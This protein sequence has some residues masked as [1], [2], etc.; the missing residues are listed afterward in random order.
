MNSVDSGM[1]YQVFEMSQSLGN[2]IKV[3]LYNLEDC[4]L[5]QIIQIRSVMLIMSIFNGLLYSFSTTTTSTT[6]AR[7]IIVSS[8]AKVC[9]MRRL[10]GSK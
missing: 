8:R 1:K 3:N 2:E 4:N 7:I 10:G 6:I 5:D 9:S